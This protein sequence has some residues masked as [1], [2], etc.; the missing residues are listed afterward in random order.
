MNLKIFKGFERFEDHYPTDAV[1]YALDNKEEAIPELL[2][3]LE[4]TLNDVGNLSEDENYLVHFPAIYLLAYFQEKKA[5]ESIIKIASLPDGQ[6]FDLLGDTVTEDFKNILASVCDGNIEPIKKI[7]ENA[8]LDEYVR[9]EALES[10]LILLNH[11]V[12]SREQLVLYFKELFNGKLEVDDWGLLDTLPRCCSLIHPE[13]LSDEV[14]KT[15]AD[16]MVME[17]FADLVFMN[18]QLERPVIEVLNELKGNKEFSFISEEDVLSLESWVGGISSEADEYPFDEDDE[19]EMEG[20]Q[21]MRSFLN[22]YKGNEISVNVPFKR[23]SFV[24]RNDPCPCGSGKK[25]K[26]CCLEDV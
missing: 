4:H 5:Y 22:E 25:Y 19:N 1:R 24:G 6:L 18:H 11:G 23:E 16:G 15:V 20:E 7:I 14:E 26:K 8:A 3:I 10:L 13:G 9:T 2:E 12:V 21:L 17:I